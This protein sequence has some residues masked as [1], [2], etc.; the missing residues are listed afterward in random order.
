MKMKA[1]KK[2]EFKKSEKTIK[3]FN[4]FLCRHAII[5]LLRT[6]SA[7]THL[8]L[9]NK[10]AVRMHVSHIKALSKS[11]R[12]FLNL[13]S[14]VCLLCAIIFIRPSVYTL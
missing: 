11:K 4:D 7:N 9:L 2:N 10:K 5:L 8:T 13:Y 1:R 3:I 12:T 14:Y 6:A